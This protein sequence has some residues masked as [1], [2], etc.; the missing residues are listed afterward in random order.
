MK[1]IPNLLSAYRFAVT[2]VIL[3]LM[4]RGSFSGALVV[5]LTAIAS[6]SIDGYVA[7]KMNLESSFG[8]MA[9]PFVD[10]VIICGAFI[11]LIGK[12]PLLAEWMVAV[13][14]CREFVVTGLRFLLES[15]GEQFGSNI[16]GKQKMVTQFF[17]VAALIVYIAVYG[18]ETGSL[19]ALGVRLLLWAAIAST[20]GSG[21][22]YV[23]RAVKVLRRT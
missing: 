18:R 14:V 4:S 12:T 2:P 15:K 13:I 11:M 19:Y 21:T 22:L 5:Y 17:A 9:D 23:V 16:L 7:R 20:V 1:H 8:R 10:K 3:Y 6:D